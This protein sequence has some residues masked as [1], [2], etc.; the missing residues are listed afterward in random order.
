MSGPSM[1]PGTAPAKIPPGFEP[2]GERPRIRW[3]AGIAAVTF[4]STAALVATFLAAIALTRFLLV[5]NADGFRPRLIESLSALAGQPVALGRLS[6]GWNGWSPEFTIERLQVLDAKGRVALELPR[7]DAAISWRSLLAR[8]PHLS[9]LTIHEPRVVVRRTSANELVVAGLGVD[10]EAAGG[11]GRLVEWLLKQ[12]RVQVV[13]GEIAWVDEWRGLPPLY[14]S[15]LSAKLL[16]SG[17]RHRAGLVATPRSEAADVTGAT[18]AP[19]ELRADFRGRSARSIADWDGSAY[20]LI[21]ET[22]LAIWS[23]YLP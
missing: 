6:A 23:R 5:P 3:R 7:V 21:P 8:E 19:F 14:F 16:S 10:L 12:A 1:V 22:E 20:V 13:R 15:N 9:S 18:P 17:E 4:W 11:D 2:A